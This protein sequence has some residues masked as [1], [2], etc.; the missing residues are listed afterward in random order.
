[1]HT[2]FNPAATL[3]KDGTTL[4]L[5][6]VEDRRGFSHLCAARS[7]NGI[8]GW[9]IDSEPTFVAN[10]AEHPEELWGVEDPRITYI[11]EDDQF[12]ISYTAYSK[13]GP[14]V[15][16]AGT[17]DFKTFTRYGLAMQPD[18]K[19]AAFFPRKFDGNYMLIHRPVT[20]TDANMWISHSPDLCNWGGHKLLLPA[21]RGGWWDANKI[22]LSPPPIETDRGWLVIY[23]GVRHHASGS[24]YRLGLAL[25]DKE[26]PDICLLRGQ[27][28]IFGPET[29]YETIGDVG[30]VVFPCGYTVR[31]DG[32]TIYLYYGGA[33]T[34]ICL[35]TGSIKQLL[36]WLD[37]DGTTMT[38]IAGQPAERSQLNA[39]L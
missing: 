21:R 29:D 13:S 35:A 3:L 33:D 2:V 25:F 5:C 27:S 6:R 39:P 31:E 38:G 26:H 9:V 34:C 11:P 22:G 36:A 20:E 19:D 14:G 18:D 7:E 37:V 30:S 10:P 1:V 12:L 15:A 4:L 23:H 17:K 32:D 16:V 8:N 24:I 28:W